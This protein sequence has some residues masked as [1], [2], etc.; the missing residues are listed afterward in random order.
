MILKKKKLGENALISQIKEVLSFLT[1]VFYKSRSFSFTLRWELRQQ[2][3]HLKVNENEKTF[4][5]VYGVN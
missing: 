1:R 3:S 5:S 2:N 4:P